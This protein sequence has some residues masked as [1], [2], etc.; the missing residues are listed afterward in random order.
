MKKLIPLTL[1][2]AGLLLAANPA[3]AA[4]SNAIGM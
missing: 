3:F 1:V 4:I 2:M